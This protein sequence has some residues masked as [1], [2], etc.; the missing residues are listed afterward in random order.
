M[1]KIK[2]P[3]KQYLVIYAYEEDMPPKLQWVYEKELNTTFD[4]R[5]GK[6]RERIVIGGDD[7]ILLSDTL[8]PIV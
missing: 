2:N 1:K 5:H 4:K 7:I 8:T 3:E 6:Y